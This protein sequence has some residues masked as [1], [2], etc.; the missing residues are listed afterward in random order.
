VSSCAACYECQV[1]YTCQAGFPRAPEKPSRR[2]VSATVFPTDRCNLNCSYCFV[3]RYRS[4]R[5]AFRDM[6][7]RT[8]LAAMD[9]LARRAER[10]GA[11]EVH[12]GWFGGEPLLR[13]SFIEWFMKTAKERHPHLRWSSS[14]TTNAVPL[15][16]RKLAERA[17]VFTGLIVSVD[18]VGEWHDRH[19]RFPDGRG[20]WRLVE[21]AIRNLLDLGV[22]FT[23]RMTLTPENVR[24]AYEGVRALVEAGVRDI[25]T[26]VVEEDVWDERSLWELRRQ[27]QL[28]A[29]FLIDQLLKGVPIRW[30]QFV[31][32]ADLIFS[33]A[34][35]SE[36]DHC[37]QL[38]N[39]MSIYVD[40]SIYT[41]HRAVGIEEFR[42]G[43]VFSGIPPEREGRLTRMFSR[44]RAIEVSG[45]QG[46]PFRDRTHFG[47]LV[48][49]YE[50]RGDIHR[51]NAPLLK[52]Y[53]ESC[54]LAALKLFMAGSG[55]ESKLIYDMYFAR[56]GL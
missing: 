7:E 55:N 16:S 23:A 8:A 38:G 26:G 53:D 32:G 41:C 56:Y 45:L 20:S 12:I 34:Q 4:R 54:A 44:S 1:C 15:A 35:P 33:K 50:S 18:G 13:M 52:A 37:G 11:E 5:L 51:V 28:T 42:A 24:G 22:P 30:G 17:R 39:S 46:Y 25:F 2:V 31:H 48:A 47:C 14:A 6:D 49:N 36:H 9:F 3:Y 40:G 43:D 10:E 27:Y 19:R 29:D 21:Q